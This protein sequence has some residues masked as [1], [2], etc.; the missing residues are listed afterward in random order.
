[1]K[2]TPGPWEVDESLH[3]MVNMNNPR[4]VTTICR[5]YGCGKEFEANARLIAS[6]PELLDMVKKLRFTFLGS[7]YEKGTIGSTYQKEI[8]KLIAKAEGE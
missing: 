8:N 5:V 1:M 7:T 2:H 3:V 6:A 4:K